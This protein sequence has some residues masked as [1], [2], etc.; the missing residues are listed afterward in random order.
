MNIGLQ[1]VS[2]A[3]SPALLGAL[4]LLGGALGLLACA[5]SSRVAPSS[6]SSAVIGDGVAHIQRQVQAVRPLVRS[7]WA[8]SFLDAGMRLPGVAPRRLG[9]ETVDELGYYSGDGESPVFFARLLDLLAE[10]D[11]RHLIGRRL[12]EL[13]YTGIG[14]L[15]M[16]AAAGAEAIGVSA[17][18]RLRMLYSRPD[19][20]GVLPVPGREVSGRLM[21]YAGEFPSDQAARA[22]VG[23]GYDAVI[24]RNQ[25]KRGY[26][27][28]ASG[29]PSG[30]VDKQGIP[31][32]SYLRILFDLLR[33]GGRLLAYN[34][35]PAP[36]AVGQPYN[37]HAD[38]RN[39]FAQT[40]WQNAGFRVLDYDRNDTANATSYGQALGWNQARFATYTL[41]ERP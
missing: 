16:M 23:S 38:C 22:A 40:A 15:R 20:S 34:L 32:D 27:H 2:K 37:P 9:N 39:P 5:E 4:G 24:L 21:V 12:L 3:R 1:L 25:L 29:A 30:P 11:T 13:H 36:E 17:E 35:C 6:T 26:I 7:R 41:V 10:S 28:P 14:P 19:D 18:N 31:D 33:P 8:T